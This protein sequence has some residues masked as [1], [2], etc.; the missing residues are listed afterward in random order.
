MR[1]AAVSIPENIAE[2]YKRKGT[3]DKL[4]FYNIALSSLEE[5]RYYII[6]SRNLNYLIQSEAGNL[7]NEVSKILKAYTKRIKEG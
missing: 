7:A 5:L 4:R 2:G 3:Q 6:L 1:R